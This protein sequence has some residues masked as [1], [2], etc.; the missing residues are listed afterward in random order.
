MTVPV[1]I[2]FYAIAIAIFA[3]GGLL[4]VIETLIRGF[5]M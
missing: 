3:V 2:E 5:M 4:F 1:S